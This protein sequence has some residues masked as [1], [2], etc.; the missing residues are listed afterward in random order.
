M[1]TSKLTALVVFHAEIENKV[2][3]TQGRCKLVGFELPSPHMHA[4]LTKR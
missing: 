4:K 1:H 3:G 2:V